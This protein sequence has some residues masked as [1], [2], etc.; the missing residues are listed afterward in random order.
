MN[1]ANCFLKLIPRIQPTAAEI[2]LAQQHISTIRARL[3]TTFKLSKVLVG[4]SFSRGTLIRGVSDVDLFAVIARSEATWG[5]R[6]ESSETILNHFRTE[7]SRRLPTTD[8]GR[9]VHAVVVPF[10]Q[11]P[12]V[13]VV[14]ALFDQMINGRP[15]Y[16]IPD[17]NGDWMPSSPEAHNRYIFNANERS[18]GKLKRLA[19][20]L[21]FWRQCSSTRSAM[22]SFHIEML[23]AS[24]GIC[25][26]VKSYAA[27][28]TNT[29][30]AL[31]D[32]ECRA[33]QDPV[34]IAGL[35]SLVKTDNQLENAVA[36]VK[37]ARNHA[38]EACVADYA[39]DSEEAWRQWNIVF[40][41]Y[42]PK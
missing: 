36:S 4:G 32:R 17:G 37:Y 3:N 40:Q 13:D 33:L 20:I 12:S 35:I 38:N 5:N 26:G 39:G 18:G 41:G 2:A 8:I 24:T 10:S 29:L 14:P 16:L 27:F 34:G 21:K 11:G 9:D 42:F 19:Q 23:L 1:I 31:A 6:Y 22:S 7:L 30:R 25:I 15:Q 28:M